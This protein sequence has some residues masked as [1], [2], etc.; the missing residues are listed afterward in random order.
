MASGVTRS[1]HPSTRNSSAS[2]SHSVSSKATSASHALKDAS[3]D[4][5]TAD[6]LSAATASNLCMRFNGVMN[7]SSRG[8]YFLN[9][10]FGD[11]K[12]DVTSANVRGVIS[13]TATCTDLTILTSYNSG[14]CPKIGRLQKCREKFH[15]RNRSELVNEI[16]ALLKL[17]EKE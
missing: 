13:P 4:V 3:L 15:V 12:A 16:A 6:K 14:K 2:P 1:K 5:R 10:E 9:A 11:S 17:F 7:G 8:T